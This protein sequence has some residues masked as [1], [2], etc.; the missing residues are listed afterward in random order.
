MKL[1]VRVLAVLLLVTT[2]AISQESQSPF[3]KAAN[4][5][6]A[7]TADTSPVAMDQRQRVDLPP[8]MA[9]NQSITTAEVSVGFDQIDSPSPFPVAANPSLATG[10]T[11]ETL[12]SVLER[13]HKVDNESPFPMAANPSNTNW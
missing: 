10:T 7:T 2:V 1:T 12:P 6:L 5:S 3:P 11:P 13:H 8:S 9:A 4:P